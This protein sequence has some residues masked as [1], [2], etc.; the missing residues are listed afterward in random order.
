MENRLE[1]FSDESYFD[2]DNKKYMV[3]GSLFIPLSMK[4][5][6]SNE[7]SNLRCLNTY[8]NEWY[9]DFD[10]CPNHH[11]CKEEWHNLNNAEIHHKKLSKSSSHS[12]KEISKRWLTFLLRNNK[13]N[14]ESIYF[15]ILYVDLNNIDKEFFGSKSIQNNIYT[16]FY[17]TVINGGINFFFN[18]SVKIEHIYHDE[19]S[20][21]K[22]HDYFS[23]VVPHKLNKLDSINLKKDIEFI[24]SDHKRS[25]KCTESQFIQF[26]DLIMG[27]V[28]Q[29]IFPS[30]N[31]T[32]KDIDSI[33]CPLVK[34]LM[35][36]PYNKNSSYKYF[37]KQN[38][39]I[40]PKNQIKYQKDLNGNIFRTPGEFH[41]E[42]KF[43]C[44]EKTHE[45]TLDNWN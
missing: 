32:R 18:K 5:K 1:V 30:T 19:A 37:K 17:R 23:W 3:L 2:Y 4:E 10:E 34:R 15:Y 14:K 33:I 44:D 9:W 6:L 27:A 35:K 13:K 22:C 8:S 45:K 28:T 16:R 42:I 40:F 21:K 43:R 25:N 20:D 38:I 39:S 31:Q 36:Y 29:N 24:D 11:R 12:L 7:L 41:R 26:V